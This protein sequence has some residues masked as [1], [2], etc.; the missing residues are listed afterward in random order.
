MLLGAAQRLKVQV[1]AAQVP[2][3]V[4]LRAV[5]EQALSGSLSGCDLRVCGV[6]RAEQVL[7]RGAYFA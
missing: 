4:P 2:A 7:I 3:H 6:S 1:R 5:V